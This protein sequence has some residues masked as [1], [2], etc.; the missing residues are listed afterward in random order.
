MGGEAVLARI[1]DKPR[2][3]SFYVYVALVMILIAIAGFWP[4][5]YGV[6]FRGEELKPRVAHWAV[7]VHAALFLGWLCA[8]LGQSLLIRYGDSRI[9]R[10]LG[11]ALAGYGFFAAAFGLVT[12]LWLAAR[13]VETGQRTFEQAASFTLMPL[14]D[15]IMF[16]GFLAAAIIYRRRRDLHIP[17]MFM[18]SWSVAMVAWGRLL[19]RWVSPNNPWLWQP[20]A[21]APLL[22]VVGYQS[23]VG[24]R[25]HPVWLVCLG[26]FILRVNRRAM[27]DTDF[28]QVIGQVLLRPYS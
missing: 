3:S 18:A 12:G 14:T 11:P 20:L 25:I 7:H 5:Y 4:P 27:A 26:L 28:W 23:V 19:V 10:Q 1:E 21:L 22:L 6:P 13:S 24:R 2:R 16:A 8:F 15:M 17:L 9:H